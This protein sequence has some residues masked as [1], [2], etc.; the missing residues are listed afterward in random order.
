MSTRIKTNKLDYSLNRSA[1]DETYDFFYLETSDRYI[2]RGAYILD[3]ASMN[4][5]IKAIKFESGR[6]LL[7]MMS[8]CDSNRDKL[9]QTI[10]SIDGGDNFSVVS[11]KVNDLS[12][13]VILQLLLNALSAYDSDFLKFNNLTGHLYCFHESWI[14]HGKE[15]SADVIWSVPCLEIAITPDYCLK[16]SVR[17]FSSERL[18]KKIT[19]TK[20]KFEDYPEYVFSN[21]NTLRRKLSGET[22]T[23]F[24]M[25]QVDGTKTEI[26][27]LDIQNVDRFSRCKVGV[28]NSIINAFNEKYIPMAHIDFDYVEVKSRID[29]SKA[30][31]RENSSVIHSML[32]SKG[33]CIVDQIGDEYS[34]VF[35]DSIRDLLVKKYSVT[36]SIGKRVKKDKLNICIIHNSAYYDGENDPHDKEHQDAV[37]QYVTFEDFADSSEFA[38]STVVHESLIKSDLQNREITLF[39]WKSLEIDEDMSFGIE[40]KT[41]DDTSYF[42]MTIHPNGAFS[43][44]EQELT[45]FEMNE[46]SDCVD[47]FETAKTKSEVVKGI[48][49]D[50]EGRINVIK[51]TGLITIP[52]SAEIESL[53]SLGD[54]KL[55]GK[56]R[57]E[58]LMSSCLDIKLFEKDGAQYY[59]VGTIGEGMRWNILRAAN[60]RRIEAYKDSPLMFEQLLP[61]MNVTFVHNGQLTV[62]PFPFK[63]LREYVNMQK[64]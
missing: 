21:R 54:N 32:E 62:L 59:F 58:G 40:D 24:I 23:A 56:E 1:I 29:Y 63:Y 55:R 19:F 53:L 31:A 42:F 13:D 8:H 60:I 9:K 47:I 18:K 20:R 61:T 51:D 10:R 11:L 2:Q 26:P 57:R 36:P 34:A 33:V 38:I 5:N 49:R 3:V 39:D 28:T 15:K 50:G 25:R 37:V 16:T 27:F 22:D 44:K 45:L 4:D 35:C 52:E 14:K 17:T 41:E 30:C 46:Y 12:E 7:L 64:R 43:I 48:I 6:R